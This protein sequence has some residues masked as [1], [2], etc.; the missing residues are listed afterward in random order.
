MSSMEVTRSF[1]AQDGTQIGYF[2]PQTTK[3]NAPSVLLLHGMASNAT[4]WSE[5]IAHTQLHQTCNIYR[6]DLRGRQNSLF[7]G[8]YKRTDWLQDINDFLKHEA[9]SSLLFIGHSMGA[10]IAQDFACT[11]ADKCQGIIL[12]DPVFPSNLHGQLKLVQRL[13]WPAWAVLQIILLFNTLGLHRKHYSHRDL[14]QLDVDTRAYLAANPHLSIS[15]LYMSPSADLK[16][17]PLSSYLQDLLSVV[18]SI[19]P[20]ENV[21][22]PVR[23]LLSSG[24]SVSNYEDNL[25]SIELFPDHNVDII[26]ADHWLLTE[27][28]EQARLVLEARVREITNT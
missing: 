20:Q 7:L 5:F 10:Q 19:C 14:Y 24:A 22:C 3:T 11:Y 21:L 28:P 25:S 15:D 8:R 2:G 1:F 13:K 26:E 12:I 27:R 16:H 23:V 9:I 6:M 17:I 4:R 18:A